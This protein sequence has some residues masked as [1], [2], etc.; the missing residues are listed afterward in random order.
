MTIMKHLILLAAMGI[1]ALSTSAQQQCQQQCQSTCCDSTICH[2]RPAR[3]IAMDPFTGID[4]TPEQRA[5]V[6]SLRVN[7]RQSRRQIQEQ[8]RREYLQRM[9]EILTPEQYV[10][11][12]EN[13]AVNGGMRQM[14]HNRRLRQPGTP[15][16]DSIPANGH[17]R[18]HRYNRGQLQQQQTTQ[19]K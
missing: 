11:F 8:A 14:G 9:K 13:Q 2:Q 7:Q 3:Q 10:Q 1:A 17:R 4:L 5:A 6:D 15:M 16:R 18:M 12:L 19:Q